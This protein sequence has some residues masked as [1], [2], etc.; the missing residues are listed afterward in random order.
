[1]FAGIFSEATHSEKRE[2]ELIKRS[3]FQGT[4]LR[5]SFLFIVKTLILRK[6]ILAKISLFKASA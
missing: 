5:S 1:M 4:T 2:K 3:N 6:D